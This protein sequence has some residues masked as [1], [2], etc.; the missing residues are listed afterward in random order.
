MTIGAFSAVFFSFKTGSPWAGLL[1]AMVAG[2]LFG[3][4]LAFMSIYFKANQV[5]VGTA[6]N[7]LAAGLTTFL[8]V[9]IW[10]RP[11]QTDNVEYFKAVGPFN[12]FTYLAFAM[13]IISYYVMYRTPFGLRVRAVGEHPRAADTLGINVYATRYICVII[14]ASC[15]YRGASLS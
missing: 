14:S 11:G 1:G 7:I 4:L 3:L 9:E 13:V 10:G 2:G 6:I 5:I 15:R 8:L 12:L